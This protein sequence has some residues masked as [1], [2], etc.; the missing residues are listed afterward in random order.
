MLGMAMPS[1][2]ISR[3]SQPAAPQAG[4]G[5]PRL[6]AFDAIALLRLGP[7]IAALAGL[8]YGTA[9][10]GY[11]LSFTGPVASIVWLPVGVGI[12]FLC[13]FG[14]RF[15]PGLV[16]GDLLANNYSTLPVGSAIGQTCGNVLEV[17]VAAVLIR[18]LMPERLALG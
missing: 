13:L 2:A 12:S 16:I 11:N 7:G 5:R 15:W 3:I 14:M 8:Y 17:L 4:M 6:P 18:R 10:L 9:E 1:M